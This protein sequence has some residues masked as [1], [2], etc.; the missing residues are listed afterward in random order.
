LVLQQPG[1]QEVEKTASG[2]GDARR[3]RRP[4]LFQADVAYWHKMDIAA[5]SAGPLAGEERPLIGE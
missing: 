2:I 4:L 3:S 5:V 1:V